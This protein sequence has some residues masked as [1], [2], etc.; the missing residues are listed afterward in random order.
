M[1]SKMPKW[2][3]FNVNIMISPFGAKKYFTLYNMNI[4]L[5]WAVTIPHIYLILQHRK[6]NLLE[7]LSEF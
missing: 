6:A 2:T 5:L 3:S 7:R 1:D 4:S